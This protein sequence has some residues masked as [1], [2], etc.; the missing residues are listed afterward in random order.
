MSEK[1]KIIDLKEKKPVKK[2][3]AVKKKSTS[4]TSIKPKKKDITIRD[5][6]TK[7]T[8]K[9]LITPPVMVEVLKEPEVFVSTYDETWGAIEDEDVLEIRGG[10]FSISG[11]EKAGKTS[12]ALSSSQLN[13]PIVI[14][15]GVRKFPPFDPIY[16]L[17]FQSKTKDEAQF[18]FG[19]EYKDK[20][21]IIKNCYVEDKKTEKIDPIA[22]LKLANK[23]I[24]SLK[25]KKR[26]T[27]LFDTFS[28]FFKYVLFAYMENR[29]DIT[30]D[31]FYKPSKKIDIFE[32]QYRTKVCDELMRKLRNY[33]INIIY[34]LDFKEVWE[35]QG[36]SRYEA[37]R[38]GDYKEDWDKAS[39]R[40]VDAMLRLEKVKLEDKI[41]RRCYFDGSIFETKI[42][43]D[44]AL[45]IDTPDM[46]DVI[47]FL[48]Q[49]LKEKK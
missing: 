42:I 15:E 17:D 3:T 6:S 11:F 12:L 35:Q 47:K 27:L 18:R 20:K 26:G 24:Y 28:E 37:Y 49:S 9:G 34:I 7:L 30:F 16:C 25:Y 46:V 29:V 5:E 19:E 8:G 45:Y 23:F 10:K 22:T 36:K 14:K 1:I 13:K 31:E 48:K 43:Y 44:D 40:W 21:I 32:Y 39:G 41:I 33:T 4:K 38:T 2:S